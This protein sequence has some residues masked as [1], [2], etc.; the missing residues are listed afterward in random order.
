MNKGMLI[1]SFSL[2][3]RYGKKEDIVYLN[4]KYELNNNGVVTSYDDI[5]SMLIK[6]CENNENYSDDELLQKMFAIDGKTI[7][8]N[9]D[10]ISKSMLFE[11]K[12]GSYGIESDMTD[13]NTK[14]NKI[15]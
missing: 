5:F 8:V 12:S 1:C 10:E 2:K 4:D 3:K 14:K 11:I 6:F 13:R 7:E 9:E 15:S